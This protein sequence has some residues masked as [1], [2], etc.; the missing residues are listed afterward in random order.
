MTPASGWRAGV[1]LLL[2]LAVVAGAV[3]AAQAGTQSQPSTI[4]LSLVASIAKV[5]DIGHAGDGRL[6]IVEQPGRIRIY[7]PGTGLLTTP[8]LDISGPVD[9]SGNEMGL[10]GL[11]FHPGYGSNGYFYVNYTQSLGGT[12]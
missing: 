1:A 11:A 7:Q 9:D 6:F 5:T 2:I 4:A 3:T 12:R 10:L 8:F